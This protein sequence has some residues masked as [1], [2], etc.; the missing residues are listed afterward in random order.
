MTDES[1]FDQNLDPSTASLA[2]ALARRSG[3]IDPGGINGIVTAPGE[4]RG[5]PKDN[6]TYMFAIITVYYSIAK[7]SARLYRY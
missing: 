3:E 5:D 6:D 1:I 2:K 7:Y 4:Q